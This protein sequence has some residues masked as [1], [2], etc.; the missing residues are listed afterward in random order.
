MPA[1]T[2]MNYTPPITAMSEKIRKY[3]IQHFWLVVSSKNAQLTMEE[4][5]LGF[6]IG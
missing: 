5:E 2:K 4:P 6:Q 1:K 3:M